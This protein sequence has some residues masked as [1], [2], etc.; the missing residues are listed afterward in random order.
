MIIMEM[1]LESMCVNI[2]YKSKNDSSIFSIFQSRIP[3]FLKVF[4]G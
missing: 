3:L 1:I 2:S 4:F